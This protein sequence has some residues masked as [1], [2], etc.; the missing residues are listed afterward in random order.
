MDDRRET[1]KFK[2]Q[3]LEYL[4]G[5][6][7]EICAF[8]DD[9]C[10][11]DDDHLATLNL[12]K[13]EPLDIKEQSIDFGRRF[14]YPRFTLEQARQKTR[15]Y[16]AEHEEPNTR[17]VWRKP[18]RRG[19]YVGWFEESPPPYDPEERHPLC[20]PQQCAEFR[21]AWF[22]A[23]TGSEHC[24]P[25][26]RSPNLGVW[27]GSEWDYINEVDLVP[28][29]MGNLPHHEPGVW[30]GTP[31]RLYSFHVSKAFL[32][33]DLTTDKPHIGGAVVDSTEPN[34]GGVLRSE[35]AAAVGL[36]KHQFSAVNKSSQV[37]SGS[38]LD[39]T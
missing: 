29:Y 8:E 25:Y 16:L 13:G 14:F 7:E 33:E 31:P 27:E 35:V 37:K 28:G 24:D 17:Y 11:L 34:E 12:R 38:R 9:V 3:C 21:L 18:C 15:D 10:I 36:L 19:S 20:F 30:V 22:L 39:L 2:L 26:N 23:A 6:L 5:V 4:D 1:A 32:I